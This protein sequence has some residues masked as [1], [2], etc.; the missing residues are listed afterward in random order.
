MD[1][2]ADKIDSYSEILRRY[3]QA[4]AAGRRNCFTGLTL[5]LVH[6]VLTPNKQYSG[7]KKWWD[8]HYKFLGDSKGS[9]LTGMIWHSEKL[10]MEL[11][12]ETGVG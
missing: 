11:A 6:E 9:G 2:P 12:N 4:V 1:I 5:E 8:I 3:Y 7:A 10:I